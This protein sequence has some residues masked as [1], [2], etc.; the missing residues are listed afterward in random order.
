[1]FIRRVGTFYGLYVK[2]EKIDPN[3]LP[4]V[5]LQENTP[6]NGENTDLW[7]NTDYNKYIAKSDV[8][9]IYSDEV[10]QDAEQYTFWIGG[11]VL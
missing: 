11:D 10:P 7:I 3:A 1:M 2:V 4:N 9:R 5:W 6:M 8:V